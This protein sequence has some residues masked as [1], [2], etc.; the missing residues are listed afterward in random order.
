MRSE[1][2][3]AQA[4]GFGRFLEQS[5]LATA[6]NKLNRMKLSQME[7][8]V[9]LIWCENSRCTTA[10]GAL[11][12]RWWFRDRSKPT[13]AGKSELPFPCKRI[14]RQTGCKP[15]PESPALDPFGDAWLGSVASPLDYGRPVSRL[16]QAPT[17]ERS[18]QTQL[19]RHHAEIALH[20]LGYAAIRSAWTGRSGAISR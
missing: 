13:L 18:I 14:C 6:L 12:V 15:G 10:Y 2:K 19:L 17:G 5:S 11:A 1:R 7:Q 8:A 20:D 3:L 4:W 9:Q 16:G